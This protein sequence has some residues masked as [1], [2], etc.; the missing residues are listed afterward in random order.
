MR[1]FSSPCHPAQSP[2]I[3]HCKHT[4]RKSAID[5]MLKIFIKC[6]NWKNLFF[7]LGCTIGAENETLG[8]GN[9]G[10]SYCDIGIVGKRN[11]VA[12]LE[13]AVLEGKL[14]AVIVLLASMAISSE[15][16]FGHLLQQ[17]TVSTAIGVGI[18]SRR[19][20][21]IVQQSALGLECGILKVFWSHLPEF[22]LKTVRV[23]GLEMVTEKTKSFLDRTF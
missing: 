9:H 4:H 7:V 5:S 12:L 2:R 20:L 13:L 1:C 8:V 22:D 10:D 11:F 14:N 17:H 16:H 6:V 15:A 23:E 21:E 18:S 19:N 3:F